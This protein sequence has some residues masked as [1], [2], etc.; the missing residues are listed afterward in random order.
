[1]LEIPV[2][3]WGNPYESLEKAEV[4]HFESGDKLAEVHQANGG[5]VKMD[6]RK[7]DKARAALKKIDIYELVDMCAKAGDLYLDAELPLGNGTQTPEQF[8]NI[9]S[10]STG[11]PEIMCRKNMDKLAFMMK[12][13]KD[14]LDALT[15]G[16]PLEILQKGYGMEDR[17]VMVSYQATS[18]VLG[19]VLPSNS[20]GVHTL[21]TPCIPMQIGLVLKP[22]S[23]EPWTPYRLASAMQ[24]AGI[25]KEAISLYPGPHEVG[26][27]VTE[28]CRRVMIFGGQATVDKY[29]GNP[30]VQVHGPGFSKILLGDDVVDDWENYLD[31]MVDSV[32]V[33]GGR[34][35]INASG[36]YAS[37]HTEEIAD[38]IAK[39]L[40]EVHPQPMSDPNAQLAAFTNPD[41]AEAMHNQIE[42]GL[43]EGGVTE[44][45][46][47][48]RGAERLEKHDRYAF[49]RPT[50]IH[51]TD[52][53][54]ALAKAEY[55]FPFVSVVECPQAKM[56]KTIGPTLVCTAL[57]DNEAWA[58][59]LVEAVNIDRLNI[60]KVKTV[61]LN[62]LQPHEGNIVD[63]LFR[64]RAFQNQPPQPV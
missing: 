24:Q 44:V 37:R 42:D 49:L 36:I 55:M 48:Y 10:A 58:A 34:S 14:I 31:L 50:V 18:P 17:G 33:N 41:V 15:R 30:N 3:R 25:P 51:A 40:A 21:W 1:M 62:W 43:K 26:N 28:L 29:S 54:A 53:N 8:C 60:G 9:Q 46:A 64:S 61:Q 11:L 32:L 5:L 6:M 56:I 22:G 13:M 63:F 39:R 19:L 2:I 38:A 59:D 57:T 20:P 52:P 7:A 12:N 16:L 35:C 47:K 23:A 27:A 4:V 45:T